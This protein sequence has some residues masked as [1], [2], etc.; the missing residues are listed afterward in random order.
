MIQMDVTKSDVL[1]MINDLEAYRGFS[2]ARDDEVDEQ[3][4]LLSKIIDSIDVTKE[5]KP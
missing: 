1:K 4:H 3:I 5:V 2:K